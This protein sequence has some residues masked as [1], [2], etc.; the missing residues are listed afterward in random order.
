MASKEKKPLALSKSKQKSSSAGLSTAIDNKN[1]RSKLVF[2]KR[3][4]EWQRMISTAVVSGNSL[5]TKLDANSP[6]IKASL[7]TLIRQQKLKATKSTKSA[8]IKAKKKVPSKSLKLSTR[9]IVQ[10]KNIKKEAGEESQEVKVKLEMDESEDGEDVASDARDLVAEG[11]TEVSGDTPK[12]AKNSIRANGKKKAIFPVKLENEGD[13]PD[14]QCPKAARASP[15]ANA[16]KSIKASA[17]KGKRNSKAGSS[18]CN[19]EGSKAESKCSVDLIIDE[20][21]A[22]SVTNDE[23]EMSEVVVKQEVVDEEYPSPVQKPSLRN[24]KLR[25]FSET[26]NTPES[27]VMKKRRRLSCD[28]Q[29]GASDENVEPEFLFPEIPSSNSRLATSS[30]SGEMENNNNG[31]R[32]DEGSGQRALR[33]KTKTRGVS[34]GLRGLDEFKTTLQKSN[35]TANGKGL[36]CS[37]RLLL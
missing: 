27:E 33:S 22:F 25:Q 15:K 18:P 32:S 34:L 31:E 30:P 1:K 8:I 16:R 24:G 20:V 29:G 2:P 28:E 35:S 12:S 4:I 11:Q 14:C 6:R 17:A 7:Q 36:E 26:G 19:S 10:A 21:V 23:G 13:G 5:P 3:Q 37:Q 9:K